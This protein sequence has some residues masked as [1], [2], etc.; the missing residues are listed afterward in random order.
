MDIWLWIT[1]LGLVGALLGVVFLLIWRGM[2]LPELG[3]TGQMFALFMGIIF[4]VG[5]LTGAGWINFATTT[6]GGDN[7]VDDDDY[8]VPGDIAWSVAATEAQ[9]HLVPISGTDGYECRMEFNTTSNLITNL[10][11]FIVV[12][13]TIKRADSNPDYALTDVKC[14]SLGSFTAITGVDAGETKQL[15]ALGTDG[16]PA[17]T[18]SMNSGDN[19]GFIAL[20]DTEANYPRTSE[21]RDGWCSV[22]ITLNS[23]CI[24]L[25]QQ[26]GDN[27]SF[28]LD[29]AGVDYIFVC[30]LS[31]LYA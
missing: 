12:N 11:E 20:T 17:I 1:S 2:L 31:N 28:T 24:A 23:A 9:T 16:K 27:A 22:N 21:D 7:G 3:K 15:I 13:F 19:T 18:W 6:D 10:T 14:T 8:V 25:M 26:E 29:I 30:R 5:G 4:L